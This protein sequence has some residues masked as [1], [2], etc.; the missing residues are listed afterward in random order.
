M[1]SGV[2]PRGSVKVK[3]LIDVE[4]S[5]ERAYLLTALAQK[6][7]P[8]SFSPTEVTSSPKVLA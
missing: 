6:L 5:F 8:E 1:V 2:E 4:S 7:S 3:S